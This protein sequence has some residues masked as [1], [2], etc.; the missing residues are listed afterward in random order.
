MRQ[1]LLALLI[2][3][4][5]LSA[6]AQSDETL[7]GCRGFGLTGAWGGTH[8][9]F[10]A[11]EPGDDFNEGGFF[12]L[13]FGKEF[14]IGWDNFESEART[15]A[16]EYYDMNSRGVH[17]GYAPY[18]HKRVHPY[19]QVYG[20]EARVSLEDAGST[21]M[22]VTQPALG[23]EINVLRWFRLGVDVGYRFATNVDIADYNDQDF[24]SPYAGLKLKFGW[25]WGR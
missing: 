21:K 2:T 20:G 6:N 16:G 13:E 12:I 11:F 17:I 7:F 15:P 3:F 18:A 5:Y 14:T 23:V 9:S 8:N 4:G 10:G 25:S 22:F 19:F 1:L 24:S